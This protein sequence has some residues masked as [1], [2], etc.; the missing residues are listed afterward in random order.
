MSGIEGN[1]SSPELALLALYVEAD[2]VMSE[3][4]RE[5]KEQARTEQ[6]AAMEDELEALED[7]ADA[8]R[9]G[10]FAQGSLTA[11]S[12]Y[13]TISAEFQETKADAVLDEKTSKLLGGLAKPAGDL[14]GTARKEDAERDAKAASQRQEQ[15][16]WRADDAADAEAKLGRFTDRAFEQIDDILETQDATVAA[17]LANF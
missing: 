4:N 11:A 6:R 14:L 17:V 12:G 10:A 5:A 1:Y 16:K 9:W 13:Y 2:A 3:A 8:T 7:K 15:A